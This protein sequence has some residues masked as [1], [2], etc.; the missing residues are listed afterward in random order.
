MA[1]LTADPQHRAR[2][3][4][5]FADPRQVVVV[6]LCAAWCDTCTQFRAAFERIAQAR[7]HATFVWLDIED[8]AAIAGDIDVENFP[9]LAIY[10]GR[11]PLHF[12]VS[13]PHETT[14]GRLVDALADAAPALADAPEEV[15]ALPDAFAPAARSGS[16]L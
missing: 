16:E 9:T 6:S 3:A 7:P 12:G 8:D 15:A 2:I 1:I 11:T 4:A 13:L 14:V 10:R 5:A